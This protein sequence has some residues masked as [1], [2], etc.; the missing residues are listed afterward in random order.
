MGKPSENID[1]RTSPEDEWFAVDPHRAEHHN[2]QRAMAAPL[3]A[4][5]LG[6]NIKIEFRFVSDDIENFA[7]W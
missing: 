4:E 2:G 3:P 1:H 7:G 5:A 6:R